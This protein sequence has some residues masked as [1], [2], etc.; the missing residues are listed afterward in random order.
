MA[1]G[2]LPN[3]YGQWISSN[4]SS[5]SSTN[6]YPY[7]TGGIVVSGGT[8]ISNNLAIP[9]AQSEYLPKTEELD[10]LL[11]LLE[12][13]CSNN[14]AKELLLI[15]FNTLSQTPQEELKISPEIV[16]AILTFCIEK[17]A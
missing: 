16:T 10:F 14:D 6:T 12:K 17:H 5:I 13:H 15:L 8:S 11:P 1:I 9:A 4:T 3:S 7:S 2:P